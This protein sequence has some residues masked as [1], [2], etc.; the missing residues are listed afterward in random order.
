MRNEPGRLGHE[1]LS[2]ACMFQC[3]DH[4][5]FGSG[6]GEQ[7][8]SWHCGTGSFDDGMTWH[9]YQIDMDSWAK[10]TMLEVEP[11]VVLFVYG[12]WNSPSQ[13]RYQCLRVTKED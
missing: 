5:R 6:T 8:I 3:D 4:H 2:D 12:G 1:V 13:L 10:G 7:P 9:G 11:A